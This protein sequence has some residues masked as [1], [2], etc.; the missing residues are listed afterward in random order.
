MQSRTAHNN[1]LATGRV[2]EREQRRERATKRTNSMQLKSPPQRARS[3]TKAPHSL[4]ICEAP[5]LPL[6]AT[7]QLSLTPTDSRESSTRR[8]FTQETRSD[9]EKLPE[10][11][12]MSRRINF[13]QIEI[14]FPNIFHSS[15]CQHLNLTYNF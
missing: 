8:D 2:R 6:P 13:F 10:L 4:S 9:N 15:S 5:T 12:Q 1:T 14:F 7:N 3:C 11:F